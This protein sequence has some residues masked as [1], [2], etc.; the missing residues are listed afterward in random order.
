MKNKF[1]S[2]KKLKSFYAKMTRVFI[3]PHITTPT[4]IIRS[5]GGFPEV[6][7]FKEG[8]LWGSIEI[9]KKPSLSDLNKI[10]AKHKTAECLKLRIWD[11]EFDGYYRADNLIDHSIIIYENNKLSN[12][13]LSFYN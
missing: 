3:P 11:D 12:D 4:G 7:I 2:S 8:D 10:I 13:L 1:L 9:H 5:D 6:Q